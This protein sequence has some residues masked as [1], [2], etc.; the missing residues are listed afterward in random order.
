MST[1]A[2]DIGGIGSALSDASLAAAD[3]TTN[4]LA[5]AADEVSTVVS[6]VF[7]GYGLSAQAVLTQASAFH[8]E[9]TELLANAGAYSPRRRS[10]TPRH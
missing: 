5:A 1:A 9:F 6:K 10:T 8:N 3:P 4:L 7:G 2:A